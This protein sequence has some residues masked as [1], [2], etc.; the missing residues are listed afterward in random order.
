MRER[1]A[2]PAGP[3]LVPPTCDAGLLECCSGRSILRLCLL[4]STEQTPV[5]REVLAQPLCRGVGG[6]PDLTAPQTTLS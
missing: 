6:L 2:V 1:E 4:L 3:H 5:G